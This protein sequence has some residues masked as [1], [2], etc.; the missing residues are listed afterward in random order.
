MPRPLN[1]ELGGTGRND[2]INL[3]PVV[4]F[5][6]AGD[7]TSTIQAQIDLANAL[8]G[9]EVLIPA[10]SWSISQLTMRSNVTLRGL[11][12]FS[13]L[14]GSAD[15]VECITG[16]S[17]TNAKLLDFY[18]D[19]SAR[20]GGDGIKIN[21]Y[22]DS[23]ISGVT[24]YNSAGF[25][26]LIF[27][28]VRSKYTRNTIDTTRLW[29]GMTISTGSVDNLIANNIV[30]NSYDSGI[31]LTNTLGTTVVGNVVKRQKI[32]G[33]Y[34]APGIDAAGAINAAIAGNYVI[35]NKFG[36]SL[37]LHPN[38]GQWPKRVAV[39]GNTVADGQYGIMLGYATPSVGPFGALQEISVVGNTVFSQDVQGIHVDTATDSILIGSN[40]VSYC[41]GDGI[42]FDNSTG[43]T[44]T[45]NQIT[46]CT[47]N[48][49]N[50]GA[51]NVDLT[52]IGN[53]SKNNTA[54]DYTGTLPATSYL[55][56]NRDTNGFSHL[57]ADY[58][59]RK[60]QGKIDAT[61]PFRG[62]AQITA[63]ALATNYNIPN[64]GASGGMCVVRDTTV[65]GSDL[66]VIDPNLGNTKLGGN[67]AV[68]YT[69][70]YSSGT[71]RYNQS[72][73]A[74]GHVMQF[75]FFANS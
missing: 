41:A 45:N 4:P 26:W 75:G 40:N 17:I 49:V 52:M 57:Y 66:W 63:A 56:G 22:T 59:D 6:T 13:K 24:V 30:Y 62:L 37:L 18:L 10:G 46:H 48:G 70:T 25:G 7:N 28:S 15:T 2:G 61:S 72:A 53:I 29:D 1:I 20:T 65:G 42:E 16:T 31:G 68:T 73:G 39:T 69:L 11:G 50:I 32:G 36:I 71:W 47:G 60:F 14:I 58:G 64:S 67:I 12:R 19:C 38:T 8:G 21:G 55:S 3:L 51:S 34:L 5:L 27:S 74:T 54:S 23:E 9:G 43:V 35:G 33:V 44:L